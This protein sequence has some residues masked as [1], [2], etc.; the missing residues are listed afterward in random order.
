MKPSLQVARNDLLTVLDVFPTDEDFL[1]LGAVPS[2]GVPP[3]YHGLLVHEHHMTVSMEEFHGAPVDVRILDRRHVGDWY[4]RKILLTL[5]GS[6]RVVQYGIVRID[7]RLCP[8]GVPEA[9]VS[10]DTPLGRVLIEHNV[11]RRIQP[12]AFLRVT[13]GPALMTAFGLGNEPRTTYGRLAYI[14]CNEQPAVEVLEVA[15]P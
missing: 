2:A 10:G 8:P 15:A 7:F 6:G 9:I 12:L 11:M 14:H 13:P 5:K 4:A 3:P 1:S